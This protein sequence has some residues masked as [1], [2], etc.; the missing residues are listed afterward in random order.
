M[1]AGDQLLFLEGQPLVSVADVSWVLHHAP[2]SG[3]V[4]VE[5]L[6]D[7]ASAIYGSGAIAGVINIV[8]RDRFDGLEVTGYTGAAKR[9]GA[10]ESGVNGIWGRDLHTSSVAF[11][12]NYSRREPLYWRDREISS[13]PNKKDLE[14]GTDFRPSAV[15]LAHLDPPS[16]Q[17]PTTQQ[18]HHPVQRVSPQD[19]PS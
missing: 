4:A 3:T 17:Q 6:R 8:L 1:L 9:D 18:F 2:G 12:V 19:Y 15:R 11:L 7:G 10:E 5:V 13:D 16:Q 14:G